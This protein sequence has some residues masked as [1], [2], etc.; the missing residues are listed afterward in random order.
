MLT[1]GSSTLRAPGPGEVLVQVAAAGLNRADVLQRRG[2][3]PAPPGV[4]ADVPGLEFSGVVAETGPEV[5][6]WRPGDR[7]MGIVGGGAMAR[8][9]LA[10][11]R[12]LLPVP[13]GIDLH[14]AAAIPEAFVTAWDAM[15]L[16]GGL[17]AGQWVLVHAVGSGVGTAAVQ[18]ASA[19]GA[20]VAGSS[21]TSWKLERA[22][23]LGADALVQVD[24]EKGFAEA[25]RRAAGSAMHLVLDL[26]G[27]AYLAE[28]LR[29][30][31]E[32]GRIVVVGL[33]GGRRSEIDLGCLLAR[34]IELRGTVLRSRP[35]E[36]KAL[37]ARRFAKEVLP[38]FERGRLR[39][40]LAGVLPMHDVAEAHRRM[41]RG[42]LFGKLVLSWDS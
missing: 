17:R 32:G 30:V 8:A 15:S 33:L 20:F 9:L 7:V 21:R 13:R 34:R 24:R 22:E 5:S 28:N 19:A 42:A 6:M 39:P 14:A 38:L 16:Q 25:V 12:E 36:Q 2:H 37:L 31:A 11:E 41:E 26:V 4:P 10:R 27:G 18:L 3:Y 23:V 35:A 29:V 40:V 1:L